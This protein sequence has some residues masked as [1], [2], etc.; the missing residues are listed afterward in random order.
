MIVCPLLFGTV[1]LFNIWQANI[2]TNC[3]NMCFYVNVFELNF[4]MQQIKKVSNWRNKLYGSILLV[5]ILISGFMFLLLGIS[6]LS[7]KITFLNT[8]FS[9]LLILLYVD[10]FFL[11]LF[12]L[13]F[14]M[15]RFMVMQWWTHYFYEWHLLYFHFW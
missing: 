9:T 4:S 2:N 1:T 8:A 15:K 11:F 13:I 10:Y 14:V 12:Q 7:L 5:F 6:L 3:P